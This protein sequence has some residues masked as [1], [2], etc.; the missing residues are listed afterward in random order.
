MRPSATSAHHDT[1]FVG[2]CAWNRTNGPLLV[3]DPAGT[4]GE[5]LQL[6]RIHDDRLLSELQGAVWNFPKA[7]KGEVSFTLRIAGSGIRVSLCD[8][9]INPCDEYVSDYAGYSFCLDST[10][11]KQNVWHTV[12]VSYDTAA[13]TGTVSCGGEPL[14]GLALKNEA[15]NGICYLHLQTIAQTEDHLGSYLNRLDFTGRD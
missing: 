4:Y 3:P 15:P 6:C 1:G 12:T 13:K 11:L 2:H 7:Y 10:L 5:A 14:F 8:H 9:W